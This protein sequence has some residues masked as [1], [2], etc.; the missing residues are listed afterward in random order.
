MSIFRRPFLVTQEKQPQKT[1]FV[2]GRLFKTAGFFLYGLVCAVLTAAL[3]CLSYPKYSCSLLAWLALAPFVW[4]IYYLGGFW[5]TFFYSWFAGTVIY[6]SLYYW[7]FITCYYGGGIG[8]GLSL[9]AW[10]GLAFLM[11]VQLAIFGGSCFYLKRFRWLFPLLAA[12]GWVAIEWGHEVLASY[13]LGFPWFSLS[14]SQWNIPQVLQVASITGGLGISFLVAF[15]GLSIGYAFVTPSIK[16]GIKHMLLAAGLFLLVYGAGAGYI[17]YQEKPS[18]LRLR[19]AIMQPNIDQYKKWDQAFEEEIHEIINQMSAQLAGKNITLVAWPESVTPDSV[20]EEPYDEWFRNVAQVTGAW[21]VLGSNRAEKE[22]MYVSAFLLNP[23]GAAA[24]VYDK[25][26][27]VPFGEMIPFEKTLRN[28]FPNV[29]VLGELGTFTKG[30]SVQHL[31][32]LDQLPLGST[33]CYESVFSALWREQ[34]KAGAKVFVNLT[35][36]A[37]FFDTAAPYQHLAAGVLRA[38]ETRRPVLRAANT[39]ISAIISAQGEIL[40][41]AELNTRAILQADISLPLGNEKSFFVQW[42]NW[43]AALCVIVFLTTL[44]SVVVFSND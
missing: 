29:A 26:H 30:N 7:I 13:V 17:R 36:D 9:A 42:G 43:F 37:W 3:F 33:I 44:I 21:Q 27:L 1:C 5:K 14:Y 15:V 41:R 22:K 23:T 2:L 25:I 38:V 32:Q 8:Y 31:M 34:S 4:G 20:Q 10:L 35:N 24:G 18:L 11:A 28:L 6:A 39:G 16:G 12:M 40:S 19:A